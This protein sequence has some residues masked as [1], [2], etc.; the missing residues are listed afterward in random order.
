MSQA[1]RTCR[2]R[3]AFEPNRFAAEQLITAY[4]QLKPTTSHRAAPE[5]VAPQIA[6]RRAAVTG[7]R[8]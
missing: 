6:P 2:V 8:R 5:V 1:A 7:G 4:E 3:V